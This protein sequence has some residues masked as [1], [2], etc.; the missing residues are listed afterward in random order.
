MSGG[1]AQSAHSMTGAARRC[2]SQS[3]PPLDFAGP[4]ALGVDGGNEWPRVGVTCVARCSGLSALRSTS[5]KKVRKGAGRS[6]R[7]PRRPDLGGN[8]VGAPQ[9]TQEQGAKVEC[10]ASAAPRAPWGTGCWPEDGGQEQHATSH[11]GNSGSSA[12]SRPPPAGPT[13]ADRLQPSSR[14]Q[15]SGVSSRCNAMP[16]SHRPWPPRARTRASR[17]GRSPR[18]PASPAPSPAPRCRACWAA[19]RGRCRRCSRRGTGS[20]AG[21]AE[22]MCVG[23]RRW[24]GRQHGCV[25]L[26]AGWVAG[27]QTA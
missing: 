22:G 27:G 26:G 8:W 6:K 21:G 10:R 18:P 1:L 25:G 14:A 3:P 16:P 2:R 15:P 17:A 4:D 11:G 9:P 13:A 23:V 7:W 24:V 20:A 12:D 5:K 19:R